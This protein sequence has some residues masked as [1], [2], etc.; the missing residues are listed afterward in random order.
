MTLWNISA[1]KWLHIVFR[2][3]KRAD[4]TDAGL[5]TEQQCSFTCFSKKCFLYLLPLAASCLITQIRLIKKFEFNLKNTG[6]LYIPVE[7]FCQVTEK[8]TVLG[9]V[10]CI[11]KNPTVVSLRWWVYGTTPECSFFSEGVF[12]FVFGSPWKAVVHL[13]QSNRVINQISSNRI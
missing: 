1:Q 5:K 13:A 8:L 12:G 11:Q 3:T 10:L 7:N 9:H 4:S 6:L 2:Q